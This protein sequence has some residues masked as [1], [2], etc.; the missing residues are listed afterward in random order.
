MTIDRTPQPCLHPYARHRHGT[1]DAYWSD[2]CR[3]DQCKAGNATYQRT[4]RR[5]AA[6]G[7]TPNGWIDAGPVRTHVERLQ[8]A[9]LGRREIA[10]RAGLDAGIVHYLIRGRRGK[11]PSVRV[12]PRTAQLLL[13]VPVPAVATELADGALVDGVGCRRRLQALVAIGWTQTAL[14]QRMGWAKENLAR[15]VHGYGGGKV[16]V[17]THRLVAG[18]Y[19]RLSMSPPRPSVASTRARSYATGRGWPG[20]LA[21]DDDMIDDPTARPIRD[22]REPIAFDEIAVERALH[23]DPV[24]LRPVERAEVVHRL[25]AA[26][27]SAAE[28]APRVGIDKR[29]VQRIRDERRNSESAA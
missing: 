3:C 27:L 20:P 25:T 26:G 6:Y 29:S 13:A 21:W 8:A 24:K 4:R 11:P 18:L 12:A 1:R 16:T 5:L 17:R 28:I 14:A 2:Q 10:E 15:I 7:R 9:G 19:D 23:G 22:S